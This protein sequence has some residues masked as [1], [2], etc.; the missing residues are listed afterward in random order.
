MS[1]VRKWWTNVAAA[2]L[3][4]VMAVL[5]PVKMTL[6]AA[7][8]SGSFTPCDTNPVSPDSAPPTTDNPMSQATYAL[9]A[10]RKATSRVAA[11][12]D[13]FASSSCDEGG[14]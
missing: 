13:N 1:L 10:R 12:T 11:G 6:R 4:L 3:A 5:G 2:K 8:K 7:G 9:H 14:A